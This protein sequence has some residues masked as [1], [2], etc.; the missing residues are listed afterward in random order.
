MTEKCYTG[1]TTEE[2]DAMKQRATE[3]ESS[4]RGK[5]TEPEVLAEMP[6][7]DRA[8]DGVAKL[9]EGSMG[10]TSFAITESHIK[11]SVSDLIRL[12]ELARDLD[13]PTV[14]AQAWN[15]EAGRARLTCG[16]GGSAGE[17]DRA[18]IR[19]REDTAG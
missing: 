13:D 19:S 14:V 11:V 17:R 10:A 18:R 7:A 6:D 9:N 2:R 15:S 3:L 5:D 4:K 8:I 12:R 16:R 1:C